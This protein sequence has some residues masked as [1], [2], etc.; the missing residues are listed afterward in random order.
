MAL[1]G[2]REFDGSRK[3]NRKKVGLKYDSRYLFHN[4]SCGVAD[5]SF[6]LKESAT[7]LD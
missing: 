7:H 1:V 5:G 4:Y 2:L 6:N 3:E